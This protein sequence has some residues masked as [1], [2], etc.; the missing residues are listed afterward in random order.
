MRRSRLGYV[1]PVGYVLDVQGDAMA[2]KQGVIGAFGKVVAAV[3]CAMVSFAL[4]PCAAL[5]DSGPQ[6]KRIAGDN[7][8]DTAAKTASEGFPDGSSSVIVASCESWPDALAA[9]GLAGLLECPI[10]L[11]ASDQLSNEAADAITSLGASDVYVVGGTAAVS[12]KAYK[13]I[14]ALEGVTATRLAGKDRYGTCMAIYQFGVSLEEDAMVL[15]ADRADSGEDGSEAATEGDADAAVPGADTM[16]LRADSTGNGQEAASDEAGED[17]NT[18]QGIAGWSKTAILA[19][20]TNYADALSIASWAYASRSPVFLAT[21]GGNVYGTTSKTIQESFDQ[22]L[23]LGGTLGE[24]AISDKTAS[25]LGKPWTRLSGDDRMQTSSAIAAWA[26][27]NTPS[28][29]VQPS[30]KLSYQGNGF[31]RAWDFADA[32][33]STSVLGPNGSTTLMLDERDWMETAVTVNNR[34]AG[35]GAA[36]AYVFGGS[37]AMPAKFDSWISAT[38]QQAQSMEEAERPQREAAFR[39]MRL[40]AFTV[41]IDPGHQAQ[42]DLSTEPIGPGASEYKMKVSYGTSGRYTGVTEY[43]VNLD[44]ALKLR[45]Y[46]RQQGVNVVMVRETNDVNISNSQ[47][48]AIANDAGA[49]LF[50]RIHCDGSDNSSRNGF[51]TMVPGYNQWTGA[52]VAPSRRAGE[53]IQA[54]AVAATGANDLGLYERTDLSGFNWCTVPTILVEMGFMTNPTEDYK[55]ASD[56]YQQQL[57]QGIGDG[58]IQ[59]LLTL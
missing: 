26:T 22:V 42:G 24:G 25:S 10:V 12:A 56:S 15:R 48:A 31:A 5:A 21:P 16:L 40:S 57:A 19:R 44:V 37:N 59:Y 47:R 18:M 6:V 38:P 51:S 50:V 13:Q 1:V 23:V 17:D 34:L 2:R 20:G 4:A 32:I 58:V 7:R 46:L 54:S 27:G 39:A 49:A 53:L 3:L 30:V 8:C 43:Q 9:S 55:L 33:A 41:A 28:A 45:D 52:I 14:E 29:T 35:K 11:T 36:T